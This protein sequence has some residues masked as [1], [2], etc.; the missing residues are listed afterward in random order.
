MYFNKKESKIRKIKEEMK[1]EMKNMFKKDIIIQDLEDSNEE[2][3]IQ[4]EIENNKNVISFLEIDKEFINAKKTEMKKIVEYTLKD[5]KPI[6]KIKTQEL[7]DT[8]IVGD[9]H[10]FLDAFIEKLYYAGLINREGNWIG[11]GKTL[12]QVGDLIDRG[13]HSIETVL[14]I[15]KLQK[16]AKIV[17]GNVVILL[18]NHEQRVINNCKDCRYFL[19]SEN[20]HLLENKYNSEYQASELQKILNKQ[21]EKKNIKL[22]Y[23]EESKNILCSHAGITKVKLLEVLKKIYEKNKNSYKDLEN[24]FSKE[25]LR[26]KMKSKDIYALMKK[27]NI[28]LNIIENFINNDLK[29]EIINNVSSNNDNEHLLWTRK[30]AEKLENKNDEYYSDE[31][32]QKRF[33]SKKNYKPIQFV[34]HTSTNELGNFSYKKDN[35]KLIKQKGSTIFTDDGLKYILDKKY[36]VKDTCA[37]VG[38]N[39]DRIYSFEKKEGEWLEPNVMVDFSICEKKKEEESIKRHLK[40]SYVE[41]VFDGKIENFIEA[42][43]KNAND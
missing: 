30:K 15:L 38:I 9:V 17:D 22:I 14:Y 24:V 8:F 5:K 20:G 37:F 4:G 7:C 42:Y 2:H 43:L 1:E 32:Y 33:W 34:G 40:E 28:T 21:V 26:I 35:N 29:E 39:K 19:F 31:Y 16:Q 25:N 3:E 36:F 41:E 13:P 27:N 6:I 10:G 23:Y 12:V 11:K 18:G